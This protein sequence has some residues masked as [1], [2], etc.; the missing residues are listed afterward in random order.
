MMVYNRKPILQNLCD[1]L[2]K[3]NLVDLDDLDK[4]AA[5]FKQ[6]RKRMTPIQKLICDEY[7]F[8]KGMMYVYA[9]LATFMFACMKQ[10]IIANV[11]QQEGVEKQ[12]YENRFGLFSVMMFPK[13]VNF[14]AYEN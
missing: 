7:E 11:F 6:R 10:G 8:Y 14:E 9:G 5:K 3:S 4:S 1:D 2:I 12:V 13:Y